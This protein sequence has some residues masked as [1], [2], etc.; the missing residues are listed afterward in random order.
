MG[1]Y[2]FSI[3]MLFYILL[4]SL[5]LVLIFYLLNYFLSLKILFLEKISSF[6]R[7]FERI[8]KIHSSFSIHFFIIML[9][10]VIFDLEVVILIGFMIARFNSIFLLILIL[11]FTMGG[12]YIEWYFG[13]LIWLI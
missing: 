9:M 5:I 2:E 13:K 3:L 12:F 6:E 1:T 7:G 8:G 11:I 10:F 4:F